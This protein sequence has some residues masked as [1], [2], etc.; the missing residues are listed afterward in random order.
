MLLVFPWHICAVRRGWWLQPWNSCLQT[1]TMGRWELMLEHR[2]HSQYEYGQLMG[3]SYKFYA[4]ERVGPLPANYTI[5]WRGSAY[6][7]EG[8]T[9]VAGF[10]NMTGG[11]MTGGNAGTLKMTIPT[12]FTLSMLAWGMLEFPEARS[13]QVSEQQLLV[14]WSHQLWYDMCSMRVTQ[15]AGS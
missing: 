15:P 11:F 8:N 4:A 9:K 6:L 3:M 10:T 2:V 13:L 1:R 5:P 12:A 14:P 7:Q